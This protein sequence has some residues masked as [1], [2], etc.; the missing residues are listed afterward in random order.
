MRLSSTCNGVP[1]IKGA[2]T[3][4]HIYTDSLDH[5]TSRIFWSISAEKDHIVRGVDASMIL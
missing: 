5:T 1:C 2:I 4:G 3:I